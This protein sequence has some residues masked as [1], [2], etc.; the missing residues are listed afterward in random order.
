LNVHIA[1]W[2][3]GS[4]TL[5][6]RDAEG[7]FGFIH[8]SVME[9]LAAKAAAVFLN[10]RHSRE[11]ENPEN[12]SALAKSSESGDAP[13][14]WSAILS[15]L[16]QK[17]GDFINPLSRKEIS[18]LMAEFFKDLAGHGLA[19]DWAQGVLDDAEAG[20]TAKKNAF[21]IID[22]LKEKAG[23][24][25]NLAGQDLHGQDFSVQDLRS[26]NFW[27]A[28]LG[29][30]LFQSTDLREANFSEA[31]V[32]DADF[33][34]ADLRKADFTDA[35][36]T[37]ANF[38]GAKLDHA[39]LAAKSWQQARLLN[40]HAEIDPL[41]AFGAALP[42]MALQYMHIQALRGIYPFFPVAW[43]PQGI[44]AIGGIKLGH[45]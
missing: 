16:F 45:P 2:Q 13:L 42:G 15:P 37:R 9:W 26:A 23:P 18:P 39:I 40:T 8:Q 27:H 31:I 20:E 43:S 34:R 19:R 12:S 10:L 3:I 38:S 30:T 17:E 32:R 36:C 11:S 44:I 29:D 22:R 33:T 24:A 28:D 35:D 5:L 14:E 7:N 41:R 21:K 6:I 1:A 25:L 4:G